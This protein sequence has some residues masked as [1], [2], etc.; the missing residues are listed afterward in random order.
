MSELAYLA[1]Q[2]KA[3]DVNR[4]N[5]V[6]YLKAM[7]G[8]GARLGLAFAVMLALAVVVACFALSRLA[9]I[10]DNTR[11]LDTDWL[12]STQ[13]LSRYS[14]DMSQLRRIEAAMILATS[15][16]ERN[17]WLNAID[18]AKRSAVTFWQ[19]YRTV[20]V[21]SDEERLAQHMRLA[22]EH[23]FREQA[24]TLTL[25]AD[26]RNRKQ[27]VS[28]YTGNARVAL[29]EV[30]SAI[31][32]LEDFQKRGG[33][34]AYARSQD[35]YRQARVELIALLVCMG[36]LG[37]VLAFLITR[38]ITI[39]LRKAVEVANRVAK[40][41]LKEEA[42]P[43]R[44]DETGQLLAA[45]SIMRHSLVEIVSQVRASADVVALGANEIATGNVD[46]SKRTEYQASNLQQAAAAMEQMTA[47]V[48][49]SANSA[50]MAVEVAG[51]VK[52]SAVASRVAVDRMVSMMD[53]IASSS[54][55]VT[56]IINVIDDIA[57]QTNILALN[58][59]VEAARAGRQGDGFAVVAS[60]VRSLAQRCA[61]AAKEIKVIIRASAERIGSGAA[62]AT[63]VG[64]TIA[65]ASGQIEKMTR[66]MTEIAS[67]SARQSEDIVQIGGAVSQLD[68]VTQQNASLVE[69]CAAA[70]ES[71]SSHAGHLASTMTF[72][73]L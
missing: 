32:A 39:P 35:T 14:D 27:A 69:E 8:I 41:D 67:A 56:A 66:L 55:E 38:S 51:A 29:R 65:T 4:K 20:F 15:P 47:T 58:A 63:Q 16:A 36:C 7:S 3:Q 70:A 34:D 62:L 28:Q 23:Y 42:L 31:R 2:L 68:E 30:T 60:E 59:A 48:K 5:E 45:L 9:E 43:R 61:A 33:D 26:E 6:A 19:K 21:T 49:T 1:P 54:T 50:N 11:E 25:M 46:L 12:V 17:E 53:D 24:R 44:N 37:T 57:F 72:F 13:A 18:L 73:R 64:Q 40:G 22:Q 10:N 71:L 52:D